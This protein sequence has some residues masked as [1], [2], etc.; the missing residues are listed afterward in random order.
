MYKNNYVYT[1]KNKTTHE[2]FKEITHELYTKIKYIAEK[3]GGK[4]ENV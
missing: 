3:T 1:N 2:L 4:I